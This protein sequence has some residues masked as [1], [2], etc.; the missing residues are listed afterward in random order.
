[1]LSI[2]DSPFPLNRPLSVNL[3]HSAMQDEHVSNLEQI[4]AKLQADRVELFA[5]LDELT[6][7]MKLLVTT[8]T[9]PIIA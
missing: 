8:Q 9:P 3:F 1:M 2:P 7:A 4:V 5:K 6:T